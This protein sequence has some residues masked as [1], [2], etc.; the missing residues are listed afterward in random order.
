M[1]AS[2]P[3]VAV[4]LPLVICLPLVAVGTMLLH[5][6][7]WTLFVVAP[8][9]VGAIATAVL[10]W[11]DPE[12]SFRPAAKMTVL[13]LLLLGVGLLLLGI[14][15]GLCL[16]MAFPLAFPLALLGALLS[17]SLRQR[18]SSRRGP[19]TGAACLLPG[20]LLLLGAEASLPREAPVYA[21][22]SS[23]VIEA[24][25]EVVWKHVVSF[26]RLPPPDDW[27]LHTGLAYPIRAE[28]HGTGVGAVRR[29]EF[30]T[31]PFVEPI[32]VWDEPR[33]L[34]FAVTANPP[35]L[36][37]ASPYGAIHPP[38]V[39][40]FLVSRQGQFRLTALP[41]GRTL[42]EGTTWYQHNLYP[43]GYWRLWSDWI[44]HRIHLQVL[45]H[46]KRLSEGEKTQTLAL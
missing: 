21:V 28:I 35:A 43:A 16:L 40:G 12:S 15:G 44:I 19:A 42:L 38:H 11:N 39:E 13:S 36:E 14:E 31:G 46:V 26:R 37:E 32:T 6:Y 17:W 45:E 27:L 22:R 41:G 24:P 1:R 7:G 30:S 20:V 2:K 18:I 9:L 34:R 4:A 29:C 3:V 23:V 33:L 5:T 8:F 25:P 10:T